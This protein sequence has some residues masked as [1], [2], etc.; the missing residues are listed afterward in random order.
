MTTASS[1]VARATLI[2][3]V[4]FGGW[5]CEDD[6][7]VARAEF[8]RPTGL[9]FIQRPLTLDCPLGAL[10]Q[11]VSVL[12]PNERALTGAMNID[13]YN[14]DAD[15]GTRQGMLLVADAEA[16]GVRVQLYQ[17][18]VQ[19]AGVNG[20]PTEELLSNQVE[21][22]PGPAVFFPLV[23]SAPGFPTKVA[24]AKDM[25]RMERTCSY[26][27]PVT[28]T[29]TDRDE[30]GNAILDDDGNAIP[31]AVT[32]TLTNAVPED[33]VILDDQNRAVGFTMQLRRTV[34]RAARSFVLSAQGGE[35]GT[36]AA[37]YAIDTRPRELFARADAFFGFAIERIDLGRFRHTAG[38]WITSDI[39]TVAYQ[40]CEPELMI[41]QRLA[42]GCDNQGTDIIALLQ[43]PIADDDARLVFIRLR[44]DRGTDPNEP[45]NL[46]PPGDDDFVSIRLPGPAHPQSMVVLEDRIIISNAGGP[47]IF[48]VPYTVTG[49]TVPTIN[50]GEVRRL[51][52]GGPTSQVIDGAELGL[53]AARIDLPRL[54]VFTRDGDRIVRSTDR[55]ASPFS[56]EPDPGNAA[57]LGV[58]DLRDSPF[59]SA[60]L[61]TMVQLNQA[62]GREG[63]L[64]ALRPE[65]YFG[66]SRAPVLLVVQADSNVNFIVGS[67][68]RIA[69]LRDD[70][71]FGVRR[72]NDFEGDENPEARFELIGCE[73]LPLTDE[74]ED[75]DGPIPA[76]FP[77]NP[78]NLPCDDRVQLRQTLGTTTYRA[79][80][81]GAV[82]QTTLG[83]VSMTMG[84]DDELLTTTIS[85][86]DT[87]VVDTATSAI[88]IGDSA[89]IQLSQISDIEDVCVDQP[90]IV[91]EGTVDTFDT[92]SVTVAVTGTSTGTSDGCELDVQ[93]FEVYPTGE[94]GVLARYQ[95][96]QIAEVLQ[97]VPIGTPWMTFEGESLAGEPLDVEFSVEEFSDEDDPFISTEGDEGRICVDEFDC[98]D[99][100]NCEA[101]LPADDL[102][103]EPRTCFNRCRRSS[104]C[105]P[106]T[107]ETCPID[108][109]VARAGIEVTI[110][111]SPLVTARLAGNVTG[112]VN[113]TPFA[114]PADVVF[115]PMRSGWLI[116]TPGTRAL[117]ELVPTSAGIAL[118][119]VR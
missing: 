76:C 110:S 87:N 89:L 113:T 24:A 85:E 115:A 109:R 47:E 45:G 12:S 31:V 15:S 23:L 63:T 67:P 98:L 101:D 65:D 68:P 2:L 69:V 71:V 114:L 61:G 57:N 49:T 107:D 37:V 118:G 75:P 79:T 117:V 17:Q 56:Y 96:V 9:A 51:D 82:F 103:V 29:I 6:P 10:V 64:E 33:A 53:F 86:L 81:R 5:A 90:D 78:V 108:R 14:E 27:S 26:A 99:G 74:S 41:D 91:I 102:G 59:A 70:R 13:A 106:S 20:V 16:E 32:A 111:G 72:L 55:L 4:A 104:S 77:T 93:R 116:S 66:S 54:A 3:M 38:P 119:A 92:E 60:R 112:G 35:G 42:S 80:F 11:D 8:R 52:A 84:D 83:A 39:Q 21:I 28:G 95:G 34:P 7:Q 40:G 25:V 1:F 46:E 105:D 97:R 48:D 44:R 18:N 36:T 58:L 94:E 100:F 19:T 30:D 22:V 73:G 62:F 88:Q 50:V 43:D